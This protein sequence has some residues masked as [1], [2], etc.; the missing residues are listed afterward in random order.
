MRRLVLRA[1][2]ALPPTLFPALVAGQTISPP[3]SR[4]RELAQ[5]I[6]HAGYDCRAVERIDVAP[7]PDT[8]LESFRP[9]VAHCTNGKKF[10][11]AKGGRGG[12]NART[13]VRPLPTDI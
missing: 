9:E 4:E 5:I 2:L 1:F 6:R 10:L 3:G 8:G 12:A 7:S 11:V 13:V